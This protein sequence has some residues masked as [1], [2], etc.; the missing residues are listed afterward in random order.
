MTFMC[1]RFRERTVCDF[2]FHNP[3]LPKPDDHLANVFVLNSFKKDLENHTEL[4]GLIFP[5]LF[6]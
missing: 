3:F 2:G 6:F 1:V 5:E 4:F